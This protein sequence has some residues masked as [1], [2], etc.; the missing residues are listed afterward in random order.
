MLD[1]TLE[2]FA[3]LLARLLK[4]AFDR[5]ERQMHDLGNLLE[6]HLL[7]VPQDEDCPVFDAEPVEHPVKSSQELCR[8]RVD[9]GALASGSSPVSDSVTQRRISALQL[10]LK[11]PNGDREDEAPKRWTASSVSDSREQAEEDLLEDVLGVVT[12]AERAVRDLVHEGRV[13]MPHRDLRPRLSRA[14][15][16]DGSSASVVGVLSRRATSR[17]GG[18]SRP[19]TAGSGV[20]R[21]TRFIV[22]PSNHAAT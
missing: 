15:R 12:G 14:E 5:R 3:D 21:C 8:R 22:P 11:G 2:F 13:A 20:R 1:F 4:S 17:R 16:L 10:R 6:R 19:R 7:D 9:S 18:P